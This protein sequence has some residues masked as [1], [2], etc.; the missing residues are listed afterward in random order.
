MWF[1]V[2]TVLAHGSRFGVTRISVPQAD[3]S[4]IWAIAGGW[5]IIHS[6]DA[7]G[8]WT[9][10]CEES[11]GAVSIYD[12]EAISAH[13]AVVATSG[14]LFRLDD[15]CGFAR[16]EGLPDDGY[17]GF[18]VAA[19]GGWWVSA[20]SEARDGLWWCNESDGCV[21]GPVGA[22]DLFVKSVVV[23]EERLWVSTIDANT[24]RSSVWRVE[25]GEPVEVGHWD[26]A[27]EE[28]N[29]LYARGAHLMVWLQS[30]DAAHIP[31]L[32]ISS[33]AGANYADGV[34]LG[35][36]TD[37]VPSL[38]D[39]G[40]G[41]TFYLGTD[42]GQTYFSPNGGLSFTEVTESAPVI[43]CSTSDGTRVLLCADHYIDGFDVG[44]WR[45]GRPFEGL[46][47]LDEAVPASCA[48]SCEAYVETFL[49]VG[50]FGGGQCRPVFA[51]PPPGCQHTPLGSSLLLGLAAI[52]R[53]TW[54]RRDVGAIVPPC[55]SS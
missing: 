42:G 38:L 3:P 25:D 30:H 32:L 55:P 23:D 40:D 49:E 51:E 44:V 27:N 4:A 36:Y 22:P 19:V 33:D 7:G 15:T 39:G 12:I 6:S 28:P 50:S 10:I 21:E 9:W 34:A 53:T 5:G 14:G 52:C 46:G 48:S 8:H 16:I 45:F 24:F 17:P 13:A 26:G 20:Y 1:L 31:R 29:V 18:I 37:P 47:C 43:R 35:V 2:S 11:L 54:R 41:R